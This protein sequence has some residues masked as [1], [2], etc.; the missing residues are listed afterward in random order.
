MNISTV[1]NYERVGLLESWIKYK[2]W[3]L[4][5]L[6]VYNQLGFS[7]GYCKIIVCCQDLF[8]VVVISSE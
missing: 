5:K 6:Y 4:K 8:W 1:S 2:V 3:C 7:V